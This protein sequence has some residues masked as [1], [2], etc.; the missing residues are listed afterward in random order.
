M[1]LDVSDPPWGCCPHLPG[2]K[3]SR[4]WAVSRPRLPEE[5]LSWMLMA[6]RADDRAEKSW[7]GQFSN[8]PGLE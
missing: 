4:P 6:G 5:D 3:G 7:W 2:L 1:S 8:R